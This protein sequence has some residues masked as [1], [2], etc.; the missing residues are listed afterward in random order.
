MKKTAVL[1][2]VLLIACGALG[3]CLGG[4]STIKIGV[5]AELTGKI[6][7]VGRSCK[8]AAGLAAKEINDAGVIELGGKKFKLELVVE[9]S[10]S[11]PEKAAS[12]TEKLIKDDNVVAVVGPNSSGNAIPAAG[13]AERSKVLLITPWSTDP[14]TT[15][16]AKTG[17]P[18]KYV[19]RAC[20][21]DV[22]EGQVLGKFA[23]QS[24]GAGKAAV[25]FDVSSDV[26]KSQSEQFRKSFEENG[27]RVV[28]FETYRAGDKDFI[29][30]FTSIKAAEPDIIFLPSYYTDVPVQVRQAQGLGIT[31]P[32]L[33]SDAWSTEE[34]IKL[35][36]KDCE[37][38]FLCNHYSAQS[39]N[40]LTKK[41]VDAYKAEYGKAPD[42]VAALTYDSFGLL[43]EALEGA[44]VV[45]R[46]AVRDS[47][48]QITGY[49]GVTGDMRFT[50]G[51]G[52]P[53]KGAVIMQIRNGKFN[54]YA[55]ALP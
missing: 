10:A 3:G 35:C 23:R 49:R 4:G 26:L 52:D 11:K 30:Q 1:I 43:R 20:F 27:G 28:A 25:L 19:F 17:K 6:P 13:V 46:E 53:A 40:P 51:S 55:D 29:P 21:T 34:I 54:W 36:G 22:F 41:F 18:G 16:D 47:F 44:G 5:V 14:K 31:A 24:L 48:A 7:V 39:P 9:D 2:L 12:V 32:F 8:N 42:D 45:G 37:G 33:G 15:L 50:P 38:F